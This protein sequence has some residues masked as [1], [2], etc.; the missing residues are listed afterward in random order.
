MFL[1][2]KTKCRRCR[3]FL[4]NTNSLAI[5][6]YKILKECFPDA[7]TLAPKRRHHANP[8]VVLSFHTAN[9]QR[10]YLNAS[11]RRRFRAAAQF[12]APEARGPS[13][14]WW[15]RG[16][17]N[18]ATVVPVIFPSPTRGLLRNWF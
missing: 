14:R 8:G 5:E 9:G 6:F 15:W 3:H 4:Q 18:F 17:N 2:M 10:K 11:G 7:L 1:N 13:T 16:R 12:A